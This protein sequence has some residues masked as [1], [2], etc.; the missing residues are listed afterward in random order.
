MNFQLGDRVRY[1]GGNPI[2]SM[3]YNK[4]VSGTI[5]NIGDQSKMVVVEWRWNHKGKIY[6]MGTSIFKPIDLISEKK[7]NRNQVLEDLLG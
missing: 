5:I 4:E 1:I 7:L 2:D 6:D 3:F